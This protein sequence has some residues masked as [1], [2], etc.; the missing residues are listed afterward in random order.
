MSSFLETAASIAYEASSRDLARYAA[1]PFHYT[2]EPGWIAAQTEAAEAEAIRNGWAFEM[3]PHMPLPGHGATRVQ[4]TMGRTYGGACDL[5]HIPDGRRR[6]VGRMLGEFLERV[7]RE[8]ANVPGA[9]DKLLCPG[10]YMIALI[11]AAVWLAE[12][13]GQDVHELGASMAH[14]FEQIAIK[15]DYDRALIEEMEI[16]ERLSM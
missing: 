5:V 3:V 15:G 11:D 4:G 6:D 7:Q 2:M 1:R 9:Q 10:C 12:N 8:V 14:A 16:I 13:N